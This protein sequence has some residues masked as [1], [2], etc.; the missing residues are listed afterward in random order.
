MNTTITKSARLS[1]E[2]HLCKEQ[3]EKFVVPKLTA[4]DHGKFV[5]LDIDTG[6]YEIDKN[7]CT[8]LDRLKLRLPQAR[9]WLLRAGFDATF[10]V[11]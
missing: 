3:Y 9:M 2:G 8:A 7:D 5:A 1:V 6:E 11:R 10:T 4:Q